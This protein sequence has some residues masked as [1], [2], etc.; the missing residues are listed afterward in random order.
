MQPHENLRGII[1]MLLAVALF[2][3]MDAQLKLLAA[4][5]GPMQVSFLRGATPPPL[6]LL[7]VVLRGRLARLRPVN[8]RLHL[9]RGALSVL[10]LGSFV[11]AVRES[12][13]ATTYSIF[14][15]AP[16]VVAALSVP[17]LGELDAAGHSTASLALDIAER[18][19]RRIGLAVRPDA[20]V[21]IVQFRPVYVLGH[22]ER[23]RRALQHRARL[24]RQHAVGQG[25]VRQ[26]VEQHH[27]ELAA[28]AAESAQ[29]ASGQVRIDAAVAPAPEV[30]DRARAIALRQVHARHQLLGRGDLGLGHA[31]VGL[32]D[33]PG[34]AEQRRHQRALARLHEGHQVGQPTLV[35]GM[36]D[37]GAHGDP[38]RMSRDGEAEQRARD[39]ADPAL[40]PACTGTTRRSARSEIVGVAGAG[41]GSG[42]DRAGR[43]RI[44]R[45]RRGSG[46]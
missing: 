20:S 21:E 34:Q 40:H 46:D 37:R 26:H 28:K 25:H 35:P 15:C 17:L 29:L 4:H 33:D 12:S 38:D 22:V 24:R 10:M 6:V 18:L 30:L 8:I 2:S 44:E 23:T 9:L 43:L 11:Y 16:L 14:M 3:V 45:V 5:Y 42:N 36:A 32:G 41:A 1:A 27:L 13:L 7:P 31:P 39:L 19:K